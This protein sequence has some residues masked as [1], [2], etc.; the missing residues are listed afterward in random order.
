MHCCV[1]GFHICP[2]AQDIVTSLPW[3]PHPSA[4]TKGVDRIRTKNDVVISFMM[5]LLIVGLKIKRRINQ[6]SYK[7]SQH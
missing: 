2:T 6:T 1:S 3:F 4:T 5:V 7:L